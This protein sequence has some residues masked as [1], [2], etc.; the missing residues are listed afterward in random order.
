MP[1]DA[2][3]SIGRAQAGKPLRSGGTHALSFV[4]GCLQTALTG[5]D[6]VVFIGLVTIA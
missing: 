5:A 3:P 4:I 1:H 2:R 6:L